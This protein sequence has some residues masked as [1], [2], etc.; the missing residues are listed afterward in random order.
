MSQ[1]TRGK[2]WPVQS[3]EFN[4]LKKMRREKG[5]GKVFKNEENC[6]FCLVMKA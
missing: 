5:G 1:E 2:F 4:V 6:I 3:W